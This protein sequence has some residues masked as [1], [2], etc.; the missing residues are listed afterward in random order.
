MSTLTLSPVTVIF[1]GATINDVYEQ[2]TQYVAKN[3]I[4]LL[5]SPP[6]PVPVPTP[7]K[8][9]TT[10]ELLVKQ[11][12][13][14]SDEYDGNEKA[15]IVKGFDE[16]IKNINEDSSFNPLITLIANRKYEDIY[17]SL[18]AAIHSCYYK[19]IEKSA[20]TNDKKRKAAIITALTEKLN[21]YPPEKKFQRS[22]Y[23]R[24]ITDIAYLPSNTELM[25]YVNLK[26]VGNSISDIISNVYNEYK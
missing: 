1:T 13:S 24:I 10:K 20:T 25:I 9:Q 8:A 21:S 6:A 14:V 19:S 7:A 3:N 15:L 17:S 26:G 22:A 4:K 5:D 23:S 12:K 18:Y 11:L 2:I 16:L